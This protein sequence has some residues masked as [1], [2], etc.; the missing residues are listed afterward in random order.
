[1]SSNPR[2]R[3]H[4][5]PNIDRLNQEHLPKHLLKAG[6]VLFRIHKNQDRQGNPRGAIFYN[7]DN[8]ETN[9]YSRFNDPKGRIPKQRNESYK[10]HKLGRELFTN[11]QI[12]SMEFIIALVTTPMDFVLLCSIAEWLK[13]TFGNSESQKTTC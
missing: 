12:K 7:R 8:A 10:Y 9:V 6:S 2:L 11:T 3:P 4:D 5:Q 1:V 13:L